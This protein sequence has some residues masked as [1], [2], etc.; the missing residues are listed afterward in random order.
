MGKVGDDV[1]ILLNIDEVMS[2]AEIIEIVSSA[3]RVPA[4]SAESSLAEE[5]QEQPS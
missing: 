2:S 5:T 3:N 4:S 1:K